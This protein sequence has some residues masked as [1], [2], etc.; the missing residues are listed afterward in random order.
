MKK[1]IT[2][3]LATIMIMTVFF[4]L[5]VHGFE[6]DVDV[7]INSQKIYFDVQPEIVHNRTMVPMRTIFEYLN[8][9]VEWEQ[10]TMTIYA[11]RNY[12]DVQLQIGSNTMIVNGKAI[13]IDAPPMVKENRTLV[14]LRAISEV[15]DATVDWD[16]NTKTVYITVPLAEYIVDVDRDAEEQE[17]EQYIFEDPSYYY[18]RILAMKEEYPEGMPWTNDN[19]YS[20][21]AGVYGGGYGC[22]AFALILSDAAFGTDIPA[23]KIEDNISIDMLKV[24]D[25]LRINNDTHS[26]V[27][28][29]V[30]DDHIV[31]AEGNFNES[32]HW[33][34]EITKEE[35]ESADYI[36]TRYAE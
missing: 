36:I 14:P 16:G 35:V 26:V 34:R 31:I 2:I 25:I 13:Y 21:N 18:D 15:F 5:S 9:N 17:E 23:R 19:H 32:I 28:L 10:E 1:L 11:S 8:A 3:G 22:F 4:S 12:L 24:G 7:Y 30:Y 33:G 29:E 27:V 6:N 20:W